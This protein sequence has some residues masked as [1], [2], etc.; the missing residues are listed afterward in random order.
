M[1]ILITG[2][3]TPQGQ[4]L[5]R[6]VLHSS[7]EATTV[8]V[9]SDPWAAGLRWAD[10]ADW[11]PTAQDERFVRRFEEV[12]RV[13]RPDAVLVGR[14]EEVMT[15][16]A[17][18]RRWE[19]IFDTQI[20]VSAQAV[21]EMTHDRW[22]THQFLEELGVGRPASCLCGDEDRL[23]QR[24]GFP[25]SV[26]PRFGSHGGRMR[27]VTNYG[28]L[29]AALLRRRHEEL[30]IEEFVGNK[31]HEYVAGALVFGGQCQASIVMRRT[32]EGGLTRRAS[33]GEFP[34]L[35]TD[36]RALAASFRPFGPLEI[37]FR[38]DDEGI[39]IFEV[40]A[41]FSEVSFLRALAGFNEVEMTL[42]HL[43]DNHPV[44][45]PSI[46]PITILRHWSETVVRHE[47]RDDYI[48]VTDET[49]AVCTPLA[50]LSLR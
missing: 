28:E 47:E 49:G 33:V 8:A 36:I 25:L 32:V 10:V 37:Q 31:E 42:A 26:K 1:K 12:L 40:N 3:G 41:R 18:R 48:P 17:Q 27:K 24:V 35:E 43:F 11:I 20:I 9:D 15:M 23:L 13:E 5:I 44:T 45:Q 14:P 50:N 34:R 21:V 7:M 38:I 30:I 16:A 4:A 2:A 39:K 22:R 29:R 19:A 6:S 46:T